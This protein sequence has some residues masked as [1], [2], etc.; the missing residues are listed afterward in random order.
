MPKY[1]VIFNYEEEIEAS[2]SDEAIIQVGMN[3]RILE[4]LGS[5]AIVVNIDDE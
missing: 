2:D 3:S 1:K 4:C 5:D